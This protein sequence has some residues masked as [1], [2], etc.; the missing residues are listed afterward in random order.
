MFP[1]AALR[2][3]GRF[4]GLA[5]IVYSGRKLLQCAVNDGIDTKLAGCNLC[6]GV[7]GGK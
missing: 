7:S 3:V 6:D 1:E 4:L 2:L 5:V